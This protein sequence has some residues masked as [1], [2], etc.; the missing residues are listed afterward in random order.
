MRYEGNMVKEIRLAYIGG[1]SRGWAR[2]LLAD[3]ALEEQLSGTVLLYDIDHEAAHDNEIIGN[4]LSRRPD[5]HGKWT[6]KTVTSLAEALTGADFVVISILPGTLAEMRIDVHL[7]E[8]YGIYQAV[9]DTTGPGGLVRA[10]RTI[11]IYTG[12]A[13]AIRQYC[14]EAWVINYTNPMA[15]CI[16][17]LYEEY[18]AIKAFGCCH[19]V[20]STQ[21]LL[22]WMLEDQGLAADV[23]RR[24]IEINVLGVNH[25]TWIDRAS[26]KHLDLMPLYRSFADRY[27]EEGFEKEKDTWRR[28]HFASAQRVKFDLFK[29]YGVI[30]AA[31]DRHLAE[32]VPPWY[33]RDPATVE[34]WKFSLT[35]VDW[36]VQDRE[37]KLARTRRLVTGEE[38][39]ALK[40]SDEE[41]VQQIKALLGLRSMV[42]NVNLPNRGQV[43]GIPLGAIVETNALFRRNEVRPVLAGRLPD[44]VL[45]LVLRNVLNQET[46]LRAALARDKDLAFASFIKDPLVTIGVEEARELFAEML[47]GTRAYL[48]GWEI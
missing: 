39:M 25:F 6:Y 16:R 48:E 3:L 35:T 14:P 21:R 1:G 24:A 28:D 42:T 11:P 30:A 40:H 47:A 41:G 7:P 15:L 8:G 4:G 18:P 10:L 13:A 19:E 29:R 32:F 26:Y 43:E 36:R 5:T 17:T 2:T 46:I 44:P 27:Y 12:F 23:D 45:G 31:G 33:L 34:A 22:A 38:E 20:F 9:G 37:A